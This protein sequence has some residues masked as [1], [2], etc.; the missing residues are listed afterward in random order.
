MCLWNTVC[1]PTECYFCVIWPLTL[2]GDLDLGISPVKM[3]SSMRY[4]CMPNM[5]PLSVVVQKLLAIVISLCNLNFVLKWW[6][7]P[8]LFTYQNVQLNEIHMYAKYEFVICNGSKDNGNCYFW[9]IWP[10]TLN[11]DLDL[12]MS[13]IKMCRSIR[14]ICM[15]NMNS[16]SLTVH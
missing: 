9:V 2:K 16:L 13:P 3:C 10:L 8:W 12:Y 15:P 5:N 11:G 4:I 1:P 6:P 7:W 14:Y